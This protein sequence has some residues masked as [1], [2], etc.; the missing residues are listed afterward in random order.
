MEQVQRNTG[1]RK[2]LI[3]VSGA[4]ESSQHSFDEEEKAQFVMHINEALQGD[5]LLGTRIPIDPSGD[6]LFHEASDGLLLSKLLNNIAPDTIDERVL[7]TKPANKFEIIENNNLAINSATALGCSV[8]NIGPDDLMEGKKHL[9]LG[10]LWQIIKRGLLAKVSLNIHPEIA[11]LL[12]EGETVADMVKLPAEAIL[13]RWV[14][15]HLQ[16]SGCGRSVGNLSSDMKDSV[17]Y[18]HVLHQL[19]AEKCTLAGLAESD[20][21]LRAEEMLQQADL[22]DCRKYLTSKAVVEG[23]PRLNLAF[24]ANLFNSFPGLTPLSR[25]DELKIDELLTSVKQDRE[26]RVF[27]LWLESLTGITVADLRED[28]RDGLILLKAFSGISPGIV[29]WKRVN[30]EKPV[31]LF[32][33]LEN[34]NYAIELAKQKGMS[35]VGTQG[36]DITDGTKTLTLG[37]VWQMMRL[38]VT[39]TL[40]K[41]SRGSEQIIKD[42][43]LI[44]MAN[45]VV[46][47]A[48]KT[49]QINSFRDCELKK[50]LFCIDLIDS[51]SPGVV[52][53]SL[54]FSGE[55][56]EEQWKNG[57]Y[58]VSLARKI[59]GMIFLLPEDIVNTRPKM[60]LTFVASLIEL[61]LR[62]GNKI[63]E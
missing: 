16:R 55:T 36:S 22:I 19:N 9:V 20:D 24:V 11:R 53:Y 44:A 29:D 31:R 50:S 26:S 63:A 34:T 54:V 2:S 61:Y 45:R 12:R 33:A 18:F 25:D 62:K 3:M 1:T 57:L 60:I 40:S 21:V 32:K 6:S 48:G 38:H 23:N 28:L 51:I 27:R 4:S 37:L 56:E 39:A 58:A 52:N 47:S 8:V 30:K 41:L 5:E 46:S 49:T 35:L 17:C 7:N 10:L 59:G 14:N 13:V 42:G 43:E 15:Y